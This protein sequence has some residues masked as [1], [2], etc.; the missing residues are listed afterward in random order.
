MRDQLESQ[1]G[2][3]VLRLKSEGQI[4]HPEDVYTH[5]GCEQ[6]ELRF[7]QQAT[8]YF[9]SRRLAG[10]SESELSLESYYEPPNA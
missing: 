3:G 4:A 5:C 1:I 2:L 7:K 9:D 8:A 10:V 6:C